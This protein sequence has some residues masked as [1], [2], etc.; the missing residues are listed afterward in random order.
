MKAM[1]LPPKKQYDFYINLMKIKYQSILNT[2]FEVITGE[3]VMGLLEVSR[4]F[5]R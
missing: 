1:E 5:Q 2:I 4:I 3:V